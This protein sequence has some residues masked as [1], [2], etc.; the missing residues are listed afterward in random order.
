MIR[1][2]AL[3]EPKLPTARRGHPPVRRIDDQLNIA[4]A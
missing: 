4:A 3:T 1:Q 2:T